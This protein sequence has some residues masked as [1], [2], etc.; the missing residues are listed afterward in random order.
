MATSLSPDVDARAGRRKKNKNKKKKKMVKYQAP[1]LAGPCAGWY[2]EGKMF[3]YAPRA[4]SNKTAS[5][6]AC[7]VWEVN[8]DTGNSPFMYMSMCTTLYIRSIRVH[9]VCMDI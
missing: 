8:I 1:P 4:K 9:I 7:G 3:F 5:N 2:Q 6:V